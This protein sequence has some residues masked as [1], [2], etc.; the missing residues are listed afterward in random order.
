MR[1]TEGPLLCAALA[2]ALAAAPS[3]AQTA[4]PPATPA[5]PAARPLSLA[6]AVRLVQ[7]TSE[8]VAAAAAQVERAQGERLQAQSERWPQLSSAVSYSRTLASEF[9]DISFDFGD[10]DEGGDDGLGDL[11][12]GQRNRYGLDL[13]LSQTLFA[14]GRLGAQRRAAEAGV[15]TAAEGLRAARA[16]AALAVV[17]AY[18][19]ASLAERLAMISQATL[20]QAEQAYEQTRVAHEVGDKSE[21]ELLRALVARDN[22]RPTVLQRRSDR[23]LAHLRLKQLLELP[24]DQPLALTSDPETSELPPALVE[25]AEPAAPPPA[26]AEGDLRPLVDQRAPVRQAAETVRIQEELA[27]IARS[28]RLPTFGLTSDYGRVAYPPSGLPGWDDTRTNWTVAL[29][30]RLPLFTGGRIRGEEL[31]ARAAT[32][33]AAADLALVRELA[34]L[35]ARDAI[36]RQRTAEAVWQASQGTVEQARRAYEIAE[37][38]FREGISTQLELTDARLA[39]ALAEGNRALSARNLQVARARVLLLPHLPLGAGGLPI[40]AAAFGISLPGGDQTGAR[41]PQ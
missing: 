5:S 2:L 36:E 34:W 14:G 8:P 35:D 10:G 4:S 17:E 21:F 32:E 20:A 41:S 9:E 31:E 40:N 13:S 12:F 7:E 15:T 1:R 27:R 11:P 28:Q 29:A 25:G 16:Q 6:E 19:D 39:L 24:L 18:F 22:E 26:A 23:D 3:A 37:I 33:A 30:G 38:R